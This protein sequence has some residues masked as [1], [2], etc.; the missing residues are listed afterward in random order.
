MTNCSHKT[1][2]ICYHAY[3]VN[4]FKEG[5]EAWHA[6]GVNIV[7]V[8]FCGLKGIQKKTTEM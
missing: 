5:I 8:S 6:D 2:S 7:G 4:L 1:R 3:R